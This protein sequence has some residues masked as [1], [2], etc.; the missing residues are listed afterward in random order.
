MADLNRVSVASDIPLKFPSQFP[1][2]TVP[3]SRLLLAI[4]KN[5]SVAMYDQCVEKVSNRKKND[6]S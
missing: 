6:R 3:A 4:K 2:M 5:E 1:T